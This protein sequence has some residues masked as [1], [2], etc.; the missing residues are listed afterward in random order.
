MTP[1]SKR[2]PLDHLLYTWS[3][4]VLAA[5]SILFLAWVLVSYVRSEREW[6]EW[7]EAH[8]TVVE[9][10]RSST[11]HGPNGSYIQPERTVYQCDDGVRYER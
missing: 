4:P 1:R 3:T 11:V 2:V 10:V 7:A 5:L 6:S 9:R 8:C